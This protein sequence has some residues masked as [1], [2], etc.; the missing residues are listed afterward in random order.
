M[1]NERGGYQMPFGGGGGASQVR[2]KRPKRVRP[3]ITP[4]LA[5]GFNNSRL[6]VV[7]HHF[8]HSV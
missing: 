3:Y 5:R 2:L 8:P 4:T 1:K 6:P 7:Y